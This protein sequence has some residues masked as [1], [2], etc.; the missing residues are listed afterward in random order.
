VLVEPFTIGITLSPAA[1]AALNSR[2]NWLSFA[3][4]TAIL[5]T[6]APAALSARK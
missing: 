2:L 3:A 4:S 5:V 6:C 1:F